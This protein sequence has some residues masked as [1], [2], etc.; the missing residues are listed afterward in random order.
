M[1]VS[2]RVRAR[3]CVIARSRACV[4][5]ALESNAA[6]GASCTVVDLRDN[7]GGFFRL[8]CVCVRARVYACVLVHVCLCLRALACV[9]V[10]EQESLYWSVD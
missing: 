4:Q 1:C 9:C 2:V 10:E 8:L 7:A 6:G 5:A 3:A